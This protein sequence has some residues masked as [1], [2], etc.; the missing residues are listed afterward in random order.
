MSFGQDQVLDG[1]RQLVEGVL[2]QLHVAEGHHPLPV[3]L[4]ADSS[5]RAGQQV[6]SEGVEGHPV[7]YEGRGGRDLGVE[8]GRGERGGQVE[9]EVFVAQSS[10]STEHDHS[11]L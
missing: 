2:H 6:L 9:P 10:S 4:G 5:E 7:V 3:Q 8:F 1:V 11:R